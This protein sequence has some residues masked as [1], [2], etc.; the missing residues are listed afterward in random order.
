MLKNYPKNTSGGSWKMLLNSVKLKNFISHKDSLLN[1]DYGINV[2]IGPNGAGK[3]SILDAISFALFN[4]HSR[5]TKDKLVNS[6]AK[7]AEIAITFS[8]AGTNYTVEW[9]LEKGKTMHGILYAIKT[10]NTCKRRSPKTL[11][12]EIE[13]IL[14][15]D[16]ELFVHSVCILQ[17]EIENLVTATPAKRKEMTLNF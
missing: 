13:K 5:G 3:T 14:G 6:A 9:T 16:K 1:F 10:K 7:K 12:P 2:I 4:M 11:I 8:E 15:I 17:G